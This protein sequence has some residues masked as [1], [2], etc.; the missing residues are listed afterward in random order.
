M[1]IETNNQDDNIIGKKQQTIEDTL[2]LLLGESFEETEARKTREKVANQI[3]TLHP[4]LLKQGYAFKK[5][6]VNTSWK[7]RFFELMDDGRLLYRAQQHGK[8]LGELYITKDTRV[9]MLDR[10]SSNNLNEIPIPGIAL[11]TNNNNNMKHTSMKPKSSKSNNVSRNNK[12]KNNDGKKRGNDNKNS[13]NSNKNKNKNNNNKII[14]NNNNDNNIMNLSKGVVSKIGSTSSKKKAAK[15][16][17]GSFQILIITPDRSLQLKFGTVLEKEQW[18]IVLIHIINFKARNTKKSKRLS[19]IDLK[20]EHQATGY[21]LAINRLLD[22]CNKAVRTFTTCGLSVRDL[23]NYQLKTT[24]NISIEQAHRLICLCI[25]EMTMGREILEK[26]RMPN[27]MSKI[28]SRIQE[29]CLSASFSCLSAAWKI[30]SWLM[31]DSWNGSTFATST[32]DNSRRF[33]GMSRRFCKEMLE[34]F[35]TSSN[36]LLF[37]VMEI[38]AISQHSGFQLSGSAKKSGDNGDDDNNDDIIRKLRAS[39]ELLTQAKSGLG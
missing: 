17:K 1:D 19:V 13:V 28:I 4:Q 5:G 2:D 35:Q 16:A 22:S 8:I 12:G 23:K 6:R 3:Q 15:L 34:I 38:D 37:D 9:E 32:L 14:N 21:I 7:K 26:T 31:V 20:L 24:I 18:Y 36:S 11:N 39:I 29:A 27:E 33:E 10:N 30:I 25:K